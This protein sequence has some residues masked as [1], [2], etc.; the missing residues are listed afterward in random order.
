MRMTTP[1]PKQNFVQTP[2][3]AC[4]QCRGRLVAGAEN[5]LH[6]GA[7][8]EAAQENKRSE[9]RQQG[10]LTVVMGVMVAIGALSVIGLATHQ[11]LLEPL[12]SVVEFD[13]ETTR[14]VQKSCFEDSNED[15]VA[16]LRRGGW[17]EIAAPP[18]Q[19][20]FEK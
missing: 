4:P 14:T 20:C 9:R 2:S 5:C 8:I 10:L 1:T 18:G 7:I 19:R 15:R 16:K 12:N 13:G 6:C 17:N 11:Y 3:N